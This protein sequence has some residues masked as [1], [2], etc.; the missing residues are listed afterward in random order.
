LLDLIQLLYDPLDMSS[1][2]VEN[3]LHRGQGRGVENFI[4][5]LIPS[6]GKKP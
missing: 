4:R 2:V 6:S 3:L 5:Q 1:L